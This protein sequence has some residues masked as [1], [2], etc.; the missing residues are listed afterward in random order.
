MMDLM[1]MM[2]ISGVGHDR[3]IPYLIISLTGLDLETIHLVQRMTEDI[4][5]LDLVMTIKGLGGG[6]RQNLQNSIVWILLRLRPSVNPSK[7]SLPLVVLDQQ[8]SSRLLL[9]GYILSLVLRRLQ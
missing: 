2:M 8:Q 7:R 6:N 1:M 3:V 4:F 9:R 5:V